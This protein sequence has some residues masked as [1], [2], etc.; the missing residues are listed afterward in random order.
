MR[1]HAKRRTLR[2]PP[3]RVPDQGQLAPAFSASRQTPGR[4]TPSRVSA[5][6]TTPAPRTERP[7]GTA[8]RPSLA[9]GHAH[10]EP[11]L[12]LLSGS[13]SS[14]KLGPAHPADAHP[15]TDISDT[16][17]TPT[18]PGLTDYNPDHA[19][20]GWTDRAAIRHLPCRK[21]TRAGV[22]FG[23]HE[24]PGPHGPETPAAGEF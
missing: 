7:R 20:G 17:P 12:A 5:P 6:T 2:V 18:A 13:S 1:P 22:H 15:P 24:R 10:H 19:D 23:A 14:S 9:R 16:R 8:R 4:P 11:S 3:R 21:D